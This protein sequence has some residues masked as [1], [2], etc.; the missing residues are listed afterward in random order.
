[1]L[2]SEAMAGGEISFSKVRALTRAATPENASDLLEF[3]RAGS[4]AKLERLVRGWKT[5]SRFDE[6]EAERVRHR[7]RCFSVRRRL[8]EGGA[9]SSA[10]SAEIAAVSAEIAAASSVGLRDVSGLPVVLLDR[11]PGPQSR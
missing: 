6:Q 2:I 11:D 10:I 9:S 8:R 4:A 5:L 7:T 3:A 1:M